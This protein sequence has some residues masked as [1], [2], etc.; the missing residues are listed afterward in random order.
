MSEHGEV[1]EGDIR[2]V[3]M[4]AHSRGAVWGEKKGH[5]LGYVAGFRAC[6]AIERHRNR[7]RQR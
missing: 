3:I 2:H 7:R 5:S 6:K 1:T 4:V